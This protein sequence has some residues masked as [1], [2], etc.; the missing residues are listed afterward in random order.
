L[1][2]GKPEPLAWFYSCRAFA[3]I[4]ATSWQIFP[5]VSVIILGWNCVRVCAILLK[6]VKQDYDILLLVFSA[7]LLRICSHSSRPWKMSARGFIFLA[8]TLSFLFLSFT[9]IA[10]VLQILPQTAIIAGLMFFKWCT[11]TIIFNHFFNNFIVTVSLSLFI[12]WTMIKTV[13]VACGQLCLIFVYSTS[14][15]EAT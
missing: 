9:A 3:S 1:C 2:K 11:Y 15:P 5:L 7:I 13:V 6:N 4:C 12:Y 14:W 8:T 10:F